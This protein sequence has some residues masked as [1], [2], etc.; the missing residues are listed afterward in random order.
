MGVWRDNANLSKVFTEDKAMIPKPAVRE[1][2]IK[3]PNEREVIFGAEDEKSDGE[4][5]TYKLTESETWGN[6]DGSYFVNWPNLDMCRA[7]SGDRTGM[8]IT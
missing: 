2:D 3:N 7:N 1:M 4:E 5:G 8:R 6:A